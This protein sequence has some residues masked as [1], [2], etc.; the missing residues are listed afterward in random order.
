[1]NE[2]VSKLQDVQILVADMTRVNRRHLIP[3][4]DRRENVVEHSFALAML[5]WKIH[6]DLA[7]DLDL[8][9]VLKY[10]L[11]HDFVERGQSIDTSNYA[12]EEERHAKVQYEQLQMD[13][14]EEEFDHFPDMMQHLEQYETLQDEESLFVWSVDKMQ[15]I[16]LSEID[17][18]RPHEQSKIS[19]QAFCDKCAELLDQASPLILPLFATVIEQ[20]KQ[21]YYDRQ[22]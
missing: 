10:A 13:L 3:E 1:M 9:K 7:L 2:H 11:V 12:T 14:L 4:T 5:C 21:T 17:E 19:Y 18:W 16:L 22:D 8:E 15:A 6:E 20:A